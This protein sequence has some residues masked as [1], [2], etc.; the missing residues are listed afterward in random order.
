[1]SHVAQGRK[2][3]ILRHWI[4]IGLV[5]MTTCVVSCSKPEKHRYN[6]SCAEDI[7]VSR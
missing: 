7:R 6:G 2:V 3:M 5:A 1:M 4:L